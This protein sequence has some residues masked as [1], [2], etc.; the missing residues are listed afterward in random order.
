MAC[1]VGRAAANAR[2]RPR[3][4]RGHAPLYGPIDRT[5]GR[6]SRTTQ[7]TVSNRPQ[8]AE[9]KQA[10]GCHPCLRYL[11]LSISPVRTFEIMASP[12]GLEPATHSLGN[13]CSIL[14][15]YG[16]W[17]GFGDLVSSAPVRPSGGRY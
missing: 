14:L 11:L 9:D 16:D 7:W 15:S 5:P 1:S 6:P 13:C 8:F 10:Q 12:A 17:V 2:M 3:S 4:R